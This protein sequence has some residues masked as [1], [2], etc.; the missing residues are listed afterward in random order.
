[1]N[2]ATITT[3]FQTPWREEEHL[4]KKYLYSYRVQFYE[5][6]L[7]EVEQWR[8]ADGWYTGYF[9]V[10]DHGQKELDGSD[11]HWDADGGVH[12]PSEQQRATGWIHYCFPEGKALTDYLK[13]VKQ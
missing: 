2:E 9:M 10:S 5:E 11:E 12:W 8:G 6:Q 1:M 4:G 13:A 3:V 7:N